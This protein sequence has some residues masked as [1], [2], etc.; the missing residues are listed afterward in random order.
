MTKLLT[1]SIPYTFVRDGY[2]YYSRRV[3]ADLLDHYTYPRIVQALGTRS[4]QKARMLSLSASA[5]LEAY[6]AQLRL[7][8]ADVFGLKIIKQGTDL[9][10]RHRATQPLQPEPIVAGPSLMD[11]LDVYLTQKG[12][13]R[14]KSFEV[15]A[16]RACGY[17]VDACSNKPLAAFDRSD[18]LKFRN[19]L[20]DRGLTG[21]S[22]TRNFSYVKAV[23]N[24]AVSELALEVKNPF[25]GVYHD[26]QAGV[27]VRKPIPVDNIRS[28]QAAC[29]SLDDDIRH[30]IA[31]VSDTGMR[32]GEAAG[33]A[34]ADFVDLDGATP[35]IKLIKHPWRGLKTASSERLVPLA[36][37]SLWAAQRILAGPRTSPYAFPRYNTGKTTGTNSASAALNKWL[38]Q[39]VPDG[40][41]MHSFR[42]SMRDRLRAVECPSDIV[43]QIGGWTTAGVGHG[44][45]SGYP[46]AVLNQWVVRAVG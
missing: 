46:L 37:Q 16:R 6:W 1:N 15:A 2:F 8:H 30:L 7:V 45:G 29:L 35:H 40:C 9:V 33:L 23:I 11:A 18:A 19:W 21:S 27:E 10:A 5:K 4:A 20:I 44:Y 36:G 13:G 24:F 28:V 43:D 41:T 34:L 17:V 25:I 39:F 22:V 31:L 3:P 38:Q 32:L 12:R 26:R 14:P 42:H